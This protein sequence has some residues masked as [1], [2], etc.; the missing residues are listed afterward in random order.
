MQ[1]GNAGWGRRAQTA[2]VT[3]HSLFING[4]ETQAVLRPL[5]PACRMP[6]SFLDRHPK[7]SSHCPATASGHSFRLH[8]QH[9]HGSHGS[10]VPFPMEWEC[11]RERAPTQAVISQKRA[12]QAKAFLHLCSWFRSPAE[13]PVPWGHD[14]GCGV[15][16]TALGCLARRQ[17][18]LLRWCQCGE[19]PRDQLSTQLQQHRQPFPGAGVL[20]LR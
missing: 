3:F 6:V 7:R 14:A 4:W 18:Q 10:P 16:C 5:L 11:C 1:Q 15:S 17:V 20:P 2:H 9:T 19:H 13:L 8:G 12:G